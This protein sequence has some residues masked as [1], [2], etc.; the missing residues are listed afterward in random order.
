MEI[1]STVP[2]VAEAFF[3]TGKGYNVQEKG[4]DSV[5]PGSE[6]QTLVFPLPLEPVLNIRFDPL[7]TAGTVHLYRAAV[8]Q[9]SDQHEIRTFDLDK[10]GAS[11]EIARLT[12]QPGRLEIVTTPGSTDSQVGLPVTSPID[13]RPTFAGRVGRFAGV[14]AAVTLLALLA[15]ALGVWLWRRSGPF[16]RL[17]A[18]PFLWVDRWFAGWAA[19]LS[20]PD[21]ARLDHWVFWFYG[22]C[23]LVFG[24]MAAAGLQGSS[25][26]EYSA[27]Y[28]WSDVQ[29]APMFGQPQPIRSDEWAQESPAVLNQVFRNNAFAAKTSSVGGQSAALLFSLPCRDF[30]EIFR[31]QFWA[32]HFLPIQTAFAAYWQMRGF[33]FLTGVFSLL[34]LLTRGRSGLAALGALW[35]FFSAHMQWAYS[36]PTMLPEMVGCFGWTI[37]L[38]LYLCVGRNRYLL[39]AAGVGCVVSAVNFAL[40]FYPPHQIPFALFGALLVPVWLWTHR[41]YVFR[42]DLVVRHLVAVAGCWGVIAVVMALFGLEIRGALNTV[43]NTTY[44]GRRIAY[45]GD[46]PV[47][48][49]LSHFLDFWKLVG[50]YPPIQGNICEGTGFLW[51]LPITF[52]MLGRRYLPERNR[53]EAMLAVCWVMGAIEAAWMI[54]PL[55]PEYGRWV[56]LDHVPSGRCLPA[57]GLINVAGVMV[58]LS[59]PTRRDPDAVAPREFWRWSKHLAIFLGAIALFLLMNTIYQ[60]FFTQNQVVLAALYATILVVCLLER[61]VAVLAPV[62]LIP[63]VLAN[64]LV[65]PLDRGLKVVTESALFRAVQGDPHLRDGRWLVYSHDF[66]LTGFVLA[67]GADVFNSFKIVP[68]LPDMAAFDPTGSSIQVYNMSGFTVVRPLLEG[69]PNK[70]VKASLGVIEWSVSPTDPALRKVGVRFVAFDEAP[71]PAMVAKLRRV[72]ADVPKIFIYELP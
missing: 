29:T 9:T 40:C 15:A 51:L 67:T 41:A 70:L 8:R 20:R 34:L 4:S 37:C 57:L 33:V 10:I 45:G 32:F 43:L 63:L 5:E 58:C 21:I 60:G 7:M 17:V 35:L 55:A 18:A 13:T 64:G 19:R 30:T 61:W 12:P 23:V 3:D 36:W 2:S 38:T 24:G 65:N 28:H 1:D 44:P 48:E 31:P 22:G 54:F 47:Q 39:A 72:A 71:D 56:L 11:N 46:L 42:R 49:F 26:D 53:P 27:L 68:N 6:H 59:L 66:T 16:I 52:F 50:H 69:Q 25:L 62:L 14:D